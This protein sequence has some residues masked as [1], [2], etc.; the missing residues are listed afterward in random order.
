MRS[1]FLALIAT[2]LLAACATQED[3]RPLSPGQTF[4][5]SPGA[6]TVVPGSTVASNSGTKIPAGAMRARVIRV[7]DGDT[8]I[9]DIPGRGDFRLRYI[10][11]NTPESVDP[12]RSAEYYGEEAAA[13]NRELVEGKTVWLEKDTS[14]T[15]Q[16]DRLLRY[17]YLA[18]GTMVNEELVRLGYTRARSYPPDLKYQDRFRAAEQEARSAARGFWAPVKAYPL[19]TPTPSIAGGR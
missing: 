10:G 2:L 15:D 12:R 19:G 1:T 11:I 7:V 18:D 3:T 5:S 16:F 6:A 14:E 9:V 4:G 8:I 17:V 13:K